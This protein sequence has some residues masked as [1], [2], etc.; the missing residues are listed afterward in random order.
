MNGDRPYR[1]VA[2]KNPGVNPATLRRVAGIISNKVDW[3]SMPDDPSAWS[4]VFRGLNCLADEYEL[5][6][7]D[8][9]GTHKPKS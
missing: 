7:N 5:L 6:A 1:E 2:E 9:G 4:T 8:A 3:W